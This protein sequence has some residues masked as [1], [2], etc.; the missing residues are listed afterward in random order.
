M[1][2]KAKKKAH[3]MSAPRTTRKVKIKR[4]KRSRGRKGM[5]SEF[6]NPGEAKNG[7]KAVFSG[8]IGGLSAGL[9]DKAFSGQEPTNRALI[10]IGGGF[11]LAT[12]LKMPNVGAGMAA[13]GAYNLLKTPLGL[14][15]NGNA[16]YANPIEALPMFLNENGEAVSLA[17]GEYFL[18]DNAEMLSAGEYADYIP[19]VNM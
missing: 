10:Q 12:M 13:I 5:L 16:N 1:A 11:V 3:T 7:A 4:R 8:A 17:E 2:T 19:V 9:I 14:A 15:E 18:S 6:F